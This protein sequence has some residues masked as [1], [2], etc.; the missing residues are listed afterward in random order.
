MG[1]SCFFFNDTATTEIY[2]LSLHD[3]L[4]ICGRATRDHHHIVVD[5][6]ARPMLGEHREILCREDPRCAAAR[7]GAHRDAGAFEEL[8]GALEEDAGG[9]VAVGEGHET[10]EVKP[11]EPHG[12]LCQVDRV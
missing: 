6:G 8:Q 10:L 11:G 2:T 4:P 1:I 9:R 7:D 5:A 3:A 12:R